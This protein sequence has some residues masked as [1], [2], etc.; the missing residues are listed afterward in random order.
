MLTKTLG[1]GN[2]KTIWHCG[3]SSIIVALV[4]VTVI[5]SATVYHQAKQQERLQD[6][7]DEYRDCFHEFE[8][9]IDQLDWSYRLAIRTTASSIAKRQKS[10]GH[11]TY[12]LKGIET[13]NPQPVAGYPVCQ[14]GCD[15][16]I[17]TVA[18]VDVCVEDKFIA[19]YNA[20]LLGV[21]EKTTPTTD[22]TVPSEGAPSDVQ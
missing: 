2:M 16:S 22:S 18:G 12:L 8:E 6:E 15:L 14:M 11:A 19:A 4:A 10:I 20:A 1:K 7:S 3:Y 5:L 13:L 17:Q 9:E 21:S